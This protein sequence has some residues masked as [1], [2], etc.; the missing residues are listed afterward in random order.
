MVRKVLSGLLTA[1]AVVATCTSTWA[2]DCACGSGSEGV[3]ENGAVVSG[4]EC[5]G[6]AASCGTKTVYQKQYVTEMKTVNSTEYTTETRERT[7]TVNKR[8][9]RTETKTRTVTV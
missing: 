8:V 6:C 9:P 7:Y 2:A 1:F 4:G 3:V 5:G